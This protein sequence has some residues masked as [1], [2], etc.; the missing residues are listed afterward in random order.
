MKKETIM[1]FI[2]VPTAKGLCG[3]RRVAMMLLMTMLTSLGAWAGTLTHFPIYEGDEG[4]EAKPYQIKSATDLNKL[5]EDVN[6]GNSYEGYYFKVTAPITYTS[7]DA[8]NLES[9]EANNFTAIGNWNKPFKGIFDG[10]HQTIS[11][12]RIYKGGTDF[13]NDCALGIFGCIEGSAV[14]KDVTLKN[15]RITGYNEVAGIVG[16]IPEETT[17][18]VSG[19]IVGEN[20]AIHTAAID[21]N[22]IYNYSHGGIVGFFGSGSVSGCFSAATLTVVSEVSSSSQYNSHGAIVGRSTQGTLSNNYYSGSVNGVFT[23]VGK[24]TTNSTTTSDVTENNGALPV[25]SFTLTNSTTTSATTSAAKILTYDGKDYYRDGTTVTITVTVPSGNVLNSLTV[26]DGSS[27]TVAEGFWYSNNTVSFALPANNVIVSA[28]TF[29][30]DLTS[31]YINMPKTGTVNA[32]IPSGVQSFKVY[33]DGG[34]T[35][36][37]SKLCKGTLKLTAPD[38]KILKISG[39]VNVSWRWHLLEVWDGEEDTDNQIVAANSNFVPA[40]TTGNKMRLGFHTDSQDPNGRFG[41]DLDITVLNP[42]E[43]HSV[44]VA[45][46]SNG[47]FETVDPAK[48]N[49]VVTLTAVPD[50]GYVLSDI[51]V[52]DEYGTI[53]VN[54]DTFSNTATFKM[55]DKDVTVTPT[56]S[57]SPSVNM[58][59]SGATKNVTFPNGFTSIKVYDEGGPNADQPGSEY[60]GYLTITAPTG[61]V[62]QLSGQVGTGQNGNNYLNV[63]DG[64]DNSASLLIDKF[65]GYSLTTPYTVAV[66]TVV[67][68]GQSI[69]INFHIFSNWYINLDLTVTLVPELELADNADNT[70]VIDNNDEVTTNVTL[71]GRTLYK[72]GD[73]N[74][75]CL[76]FDVTDFTGTPLEGATVKELLPTSNLDNT[77]KLTLNFSDNLTAIDAG[78]PYIVKWATPEIALTISTDADWETFA[79][80]VNNGTEEY[81]DKTVKLAADINVSTTVGT[82]GH[83]F[84]GTFDGDGHTMTLSITDKSNQGTAPFRYINGATIKN[85]KTGGTVTGTMH[86]AGLVGFAHGTNSIK[87]CVVAA[88]VGCGGSSHTHCGGILGHGV[89]SNTTI[90]DCL[91]SGSISGATTA[92][93]IIFGWGDSGNH[94]IINCMANGTYSGGSPDLMKGAGNKTATNCYKNQDSGSYGTYTTD[95]GDDLVTLLGNGWENNGGDVMPKMNMPVPDIVNPKFSGVTIDK[96]APA[97]VEFTG[98]SFVGTYNPFA[99]TNENKNSILLL[100]AGNKLGFAKNPRTLGAFRAYFDFSANG[101]APAISSYELNFGEDDDENTTGIIEVNT[102]NTNLTNK[103]EGV[104]DLQGRRIANGQKPT[105]KGLYI[106]NGK[107]IV[108]K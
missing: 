83:P 30:S 60:D 98:G 11:G 15:T 31:L 97:P 51:Q 78:K 70:T 86:C 82:S 94:S 47:H 56:F 12:I 48:V 7:S 29:T 26:T 81:A 49:D 57:N 28:P 106:V 17:A 33:D 84:R 13:K 40:Y 64:T 20:V 61:Y 37:Y 59:A 77:G 88:T 35:A 54:W 87:N 91:F 107:K 85:M 38:N 80:N 108:I 19:C 72:D 105:A 103:A 8:W 90:S 96:T 25:H 102:N 62:L 14:V 50:A 32:T 75:L 101:G 1:R 100:A 58:P 92:T 21:Y 76:P 41:L 9:S 22:S 66:P 4:T 67:S 52:T 3:A 39:A 71:Q 43:T 24:G 93:G 99:I 5:A 55:R 95:T 65:K 6:N 89:S 27:N 45:N 46:V 2:S 18:T 74:T 16:A 34:S 36:S 68:S 69:T 23:G 42:N 104:F 73:W 10:N 53:N 44:T 79:S 63:Y